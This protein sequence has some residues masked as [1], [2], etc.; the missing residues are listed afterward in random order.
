MQGKSCFNFKAREP[1]LFK[2]LAVL[3]KSAL[4]SYR[5]QGFV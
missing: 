4:A 1:A 3:T 2:E 5:A